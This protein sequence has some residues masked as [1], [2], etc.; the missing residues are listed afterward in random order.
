MNQLESF[1]S[2]AERLTMNGKPVIYRENAKTVLSMNADAFQE[3][4]LCDGITLNMGDACAY[5]C[6]YCYV[7]P[8][9]RKLLHGLLD[10]KAHENVVVRR[11]NARDILRQQLVNKNGQPKYQ[12][13]NDRRVVY[14]STLVD[15]AANMELLRETAEA[16]QVIFALTNWQ[17]R[18]LTKSNLLPKLVEL[19][20]AEHHPRL[21]LGVSTGTL[22]DRVAKAIEI[23]TPL[24]SQRLKS[25]H[26][27]QDAGLRTFGM[28][29]PSLPQADYNRFAT[30]MAEAIRVEK[31]EEVWAEVINVRG[32]SFTHTH[33]ALVAAGL[34][35]E[36]E[37][38]AGVTHNKVAWEAYARATFEAHAQFIPPE[39]LRF[40]QYVGKGTLTH[41]NQQRPRGAV[42]LGAYANTPQPSGE[43]EAA[44]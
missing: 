12:D 15:V 35:D 9:M 7:G 28:I 16:C 13:P 25:L 33:D 31:C 17:V 29:C 20:P 14:S 37:M 10:G 38:L 24:V 30:E 41:W 19:I 3:K 22:D 44:Q 32:P 4:L 2:Q 40:L 42:L 23:G 18:L 34:N 11:R 5:S 27:L 6:S 43:T 26:E 1:P 39:K 8:Q 36:A 21:I